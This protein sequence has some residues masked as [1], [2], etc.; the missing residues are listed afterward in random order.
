[1]EGEGLLLVA[2][3]ARLRGGGG[4]VPVCEDGEEDRGG[5]FD[6]EE[7]AP[8]VEVGFDAEDGE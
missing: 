4:E 8:R 2:E 5:A 1:M 6:D 3:E 7:V